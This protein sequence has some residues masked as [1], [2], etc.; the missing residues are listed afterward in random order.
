[1]TQLPDTTVDLTPGELAA[2]LHLSGVRLS[3]TM[4]PTRAKLTTWVRAGLSRAGLPAVRELAATSAALDDQ[5]SRGEITPTEATRLVRQLWRSTARDEACTLFGNALA[6][7]GPLAG[8][9]R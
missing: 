1:M 5:L 8:W 9:L 4:T 7:I 2:A 3:P 6:G